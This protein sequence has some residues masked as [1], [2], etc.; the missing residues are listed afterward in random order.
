MTRFLL[1]FAA[2]LLMAATATAQDGAQITVGAFAT[3]NNGNTVSVENLGLALAGQFCYRGAC[4][5]GEALGN[6]GNPAR[7]RYWGSY[8]VVRYR[9]LRLSG[10]GGFYRFGNGNGGF[11]QAGLALNRFSA[12]GRYGNRN[13]V[14]AQGRFNVLN[15]ERLDLGPFYRYSRQDNEAGQRWRQHQAG[16]MLTFK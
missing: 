11:G 15:L 9:S 3:T 2:I 5:G 14:E 13:F 6:D 1:I 4:A 10:G 12:W 8:D 16:L 7:S